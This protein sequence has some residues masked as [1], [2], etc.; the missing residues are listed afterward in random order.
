[1]KYVE[2]ELRNAISHNG[3]WL[4]YSLQV[5]MFIPDTEFP[6]GNSMAGNLGQTCVQGTDNFGLVVKRFLVLPD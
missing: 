3:I 4:P 2:N 6:R 1:M 5:I